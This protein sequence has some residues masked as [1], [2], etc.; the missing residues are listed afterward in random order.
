MSFISKLFGKKEIIE[1]VD[2]SILGADMHSH[3]IPGIDDGCQKIE[4]SVDI[5]RNLK[6]LGYKKLI[7]TPHIQ[8]DRFKNNRQIIMAGLDDLKMELIKNSIDI[9]MEAAAEYLIDDGFT[10]KYKN[11][12]LMTFGDRF[13]LV[14]LSYFSEPF[15]LKNIFFDLQ[16]SGYKVVLAHPERYVYWHNR[17]EIYQELFDRNIYL[18]LNINSLTGWYSK[19]SKIV[20]E[21]LIDKKLIRFLGSDTHNH[22]YLS[23]LQK[24]TSQPYLRKALETNQI[25]NS[26]I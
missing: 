18:Q 17:I 7:T 9:E 3:L 24:S 16:T 4:E 15:N 22:V 25:L 6:A 21:K 8:N 13:L 14:E 5:I 2:M 12:K 10:D 23:E 11:E 20:A 19:E 26:K 1:P